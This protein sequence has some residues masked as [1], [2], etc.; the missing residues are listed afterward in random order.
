MINLAVIQ[1]DYPSPSQL[2]GEQPTS[3]RRPLIDIQGRISQYYY[4][5]TIYMYHQGSRCECAATKFL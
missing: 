2:S 1:L 4:L 5:Q 3:S